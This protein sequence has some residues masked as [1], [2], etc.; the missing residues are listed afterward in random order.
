MLT[1]AHPFILAALVGLLG[2]AAASGQTV[3]IQTDTT[4]L[5]VQ[6][7][8]FATL[9]VR[10]SAAPA[11]TVTVTP[12]LLSG[13]TELY[14]CTVVRFALWKGGDYVDFTDVALY[15]GQTPLS[16]AN[17]VKYITDGDYNGTFVH[18]SMS[19]FIIQGGGYKLANN[20]IESVPADAAVPNEPKRSNLRGT[21]A[22]AKLGGNP[23]SATS[24][25]FFN[26][27]DNTANLDFQ[28]GGFTAFGEIIAGLDTVDAIAA[29]PTVN[30]GGALTDLP[31]HDYTEGGGVNGD[32][33]VW[34]DSA[35][36]LLSPSLTFTPANYSTWQEMVFHAAPDD[37]GAADT[38]RFQLS[39]PSGAGLAAQTVT[40]NEGDR[41]VGI[42]VNGGAGVVPEAG[43]LAVQVKLAAPP[44]AGST[45]LTVSRVAGDSDIGVQSGGT[46]DFTAAN[47]NVYQVVTLAAADDIDVGDG[48]AI[49]RLAGSGVHTEQFR[50][51]EA[52]DDELAVI[53]DQASLALAEG[54]MATV[55]ARLSHQPTA[56]VRL[57]VAN[58]GGDPSI[59]VLP[60]V[61]VAVGGTAFDIELYP[62]AAPLTVANFLRYIRDGAYEG[63]FFQRSVPGFVIQAGGFRLSAEYAVEDVLTYPAVPNEP[64]LSNTRG[65]L[66]MAKQEGDPNSATSQWFVNLAD[67]SANLDAQN[68]G[69][70]VF[71]AVARDGMGVADA[72]ANLPIYDLE[73]FLE[74]LSEGVDYYG[75]LGTV[76]MFS[77]PAEG[78]SP[79]V[80]DLVTF[81]VSEV[82]S[83]IVFSSDNWDEFQ[84]I[85]VAAVRDGDVCPGQATL[86][87][88]VAG[89]QAAPAVL[90]ASCTDADV[91]AV[92]CE[93]Y[94]TT[95]VEGGT[96]AV[97]V[98]LAY[99]PCGPAEVRLSVTGDPG[100]TVAGPAAL[101]F[102]PDNW[103]TFQVVTLSGTEDDDVVGGAAV[104]GLAA[105]GAAGA[106]V[107]VTFADD[108]VVALRAEPASITVPEGGTAAFT[109][110]L[111]HQPP[112]PMT[113]DV[114]TAARFG[115]L[116]VTQGAQLT[117]GLTD[118]ATPQAVHVVAAEDDGNRAEESLALE[119]VR[120]GAGEPYAGDVQ[121]PVSVPDDDVWLTVRHEGDGGTVPDG[122]RLLDT[123]DE[124]PLELAATPGAGSVLR[125]WTCT[126][127]A[128]LASLRTPQTRIVS[129]PAGGELTVTAVFSLDGDGDG[130]ADDWEQA[131]AD[132]DADDA[133]LSPADVAP[134]ADFDHDGYPNR[135]EYER[136]MDP[137]RYVLPLRQGWNLIGLAGPPVDNRV[138]A[139]LGMDGRAA[140]ALP[141]WRAEDDAYAVAVEF[142][143]TRGYWVYAT[144][145]EE[146]TITAA[147]PA[148]ADLPALGVGWNLVSVPCLPEDNSPAAVF[149]GAAAGSVWTWAGQ[150]YVRAT[151]IVPLRGY[152]VHVPPWVP[153][154]ANP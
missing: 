32:H 136:D 16:V 89:S 56:T 100:V 88:F 17:L 123:T 67:N 49:I 68:G 127:P 142:E 87:A 59:A 29:L 114:R 75:A 58:V 14:P 107:H 28:N 77:L 52:D 25:W 151:G 79:Q 65:T 45:R 43:T 152:W 1:R 132:A 81:A 103:G 148:S 108:D 97:G 35:S 85:R 121:I 55:R 40:I 22:M 96:A 86:H 6:E 95:V 69:F 10:L 31:V 61:Q 112:Q 23:D 150:G 129:A 26:L 102:T 30:L 91:Q 73:T 9:R 42:V 18:R 41:A 7:G 133:I 124:L 38:A 47:W 62:H 92:L 130:L 51:T 90:T 50:A 131:I 12:A 54:G 115:R 99:R 117:F 19:G 154:R 53:L 39:G 141:A 64:G 24:E 126:D 120:V 48:E 60:A 5:S 105:D 111:S 104:L 116:E 34:V 37:D 125:R 147:G 76:P 106:S 94:A 72:I 33:L 4:A 74:G 27:A 66:A 138:T 78:G 110:R 36:V 134:E 2:L 63:A 143:A 15:D 135:E 13:S 140:V 144:A 3:Q 153:S 119:I 46:L 146:I 84:E 145:D 20:A 122:A 70:T 128:A 71:G 8:S 21:I 83:A 118:W 139:V 137:T 57:S 98:A 113:F 82:A 11:G 93:T 109:V 44:P 101:T 149:G 80:S